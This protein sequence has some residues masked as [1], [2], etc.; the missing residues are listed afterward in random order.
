MSYELVEGVIY[1][2]IIGAVASAVVMAVIEFRIWWEK[3][4][5][6]RWAS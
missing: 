6:R 2:V 5:R 1:G 3:R 4:G